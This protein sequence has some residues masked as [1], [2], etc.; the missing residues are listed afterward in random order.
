MADVTYSTLPRVSGKGIHSWLETEGVVALITGITYQHFG[1]FPWFSKE[2]KIKKNQ[3]I[4]VLKNC[5]Y[6][7]RLRHSI[8]T[9]DW[10]VFEYGHTCMSGILYTPDT[11]I[12]PAG[13]GWHQSP[14]RPHDNV[15]HNPYRTVSLRALLPSHIL[16]NKPLHLLQK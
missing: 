12:L 10:L 7:T 4:N 9:D 11:A 3:D 13:W 5:N 16:H 15:G 6:D 8:C 2:N 1:I 14:S